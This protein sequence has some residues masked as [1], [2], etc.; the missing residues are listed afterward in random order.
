MKLIAFLFRESSYKVV[1]AVLAGIVA[2]VCNTGLL[3]L[4]S[5]ALINADSRVNM[6]WKFIAL[7]VVMLVC[8]VT[9]EVLLARLSMRAIAELRIKLS[10]KILAAPLR[11]LEQLGAHRLLATLT[12]EA[13]VLVNAL[14]ALPLVCMNM[15]VVITCLVYLGWLSWQLLL[16]VFG[17][18][19]FGLITYQLPLKTAVRYLDRSREQ[20]DALFKHFRSL[21]DG[22]K[23]LKL[24]QQRQDAFIS[25]QLRKTSDLFVKYNATGQ[26]IF[27]LA[28]GWGHMLIFVLIGSLIFAS[29]LVVTID[30]K[31]LTAYS[32]AILYMMTPLEVI[33]GE[34]SIFG[35]AVVALKKIDNLG[36]TLDAH[37][38][39]DVSTAGRPSIAFWQSLELAG[40]THTYFKEGEDTSFTLGPIDLELKPGELVFIAGA[41]GSG[42]TSLAKLLVGLYTPE[43]GEIRFNGKTV[44][45]ESRKSY[46]QLFSVV[47]SDFFLFQH[48]LGLEKP[49]LDDEARQYLVRLNLHKK[50]QVRDGMLSSTD[51]SQGQRKRL[52]LLTAYLEDRPIYLFDEWAADQD[53]QFKEVF[54]YQLLPD[55]KSRGKTVVVI[56]HDDRYYGVADRLIKL[57]YGK[58]EFDKRVEDSGQGLTEAVAVIN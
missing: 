54:Y 22:V 53:P 21:T 11:Q 47:F 36:L 29:H 38:G 55:L 14:T 34:T 3:A 30:A 23:E 57:D 42:K 26:T 37:Q 58:I 48:L 18:L 28:S 33:I 46:R 10:R 40:V 15:A 19:V 41:N 50:V 49:E 25:K 51:L 2:G 8:R 32:I 6:L 16:W 27:S 13:P 56:T 7:C 39:E 52:A 31:T 12:E 24:H 35:R 1:I 45:D 44:G 17:F 5:S 4:I 43:A 9:S 20:W